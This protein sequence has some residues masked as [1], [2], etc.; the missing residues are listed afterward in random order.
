M[1]LKKIYK[2]IYFGP[3]IVKYV[4]EYG[5][6][7]GLLFCFQFPIERNWAKFCIKM[8]LKIDKADWWVGKWLDIIISYMFQTNGINSD[9]ER[10]AK[11]I[12]E[13]DFLW[14]I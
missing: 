5:S 14:T 8:L 2:N 10:I 11:D 13:S 12:S 3:G 6:E 1:D 7:Y 4:I 9:Q